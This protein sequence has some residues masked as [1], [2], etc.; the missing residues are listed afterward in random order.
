LDPE[1]DSLLYDDDDSS[2]EEVIEVIVDDD[3]SETSDADEEMSGE[4]DDD[5]SGN[6]E[7]EALGDDDEDEE[8]SEDEEKLQLRQQLAQLQERERRLAYEQEQRK[9]QAYW[10]QI[11]GQAQEYFAWKEQA[12]WAEKDNRLNP[13]GFLQ[14]QLAQLRLEQADWYRQFGNSINEARRQQYE[15]NAIPGW[16]AKIASHYGLSEEQ[17]RD[18]LDYHPNQM[19]REAEKMARTNARIA[20]LESAKKQE[21]RGKARSARFGGGKSPQTGGGSRPP[22]KRVKAGSDAHLKALFG[23]TTRGA[24]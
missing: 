16:A 9:N 21:Q 8:L 18:L 20:K 2:D 17:E 14:E 5:E 19:K 11:E 12:I 10:D 7:S 24:I 1:D 23:V 3:E 22:T 6:D 15:R 13:E 4:L